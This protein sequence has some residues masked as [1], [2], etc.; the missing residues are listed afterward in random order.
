[1]GAFL[2]EIHLNKRAARL[3]MFTQAYL[4]SHNMVDSR[5]TYNLVPEAVR[6]ATC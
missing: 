6:P 5:N 1:M 2:D 3:I 4:G